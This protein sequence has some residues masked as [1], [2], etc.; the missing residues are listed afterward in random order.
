M[1][2]NRLRSIH[3]DDRPRQK[4]DEII[5]YVHRNGPDS[6][7]ILQQLSLYKEFSP[8]EFAEGEEHL[9]SSMGLFYKIGDAETIYSLIMKSVGSANTTTSGDILTPVQASVRNA[10]SANKYVSISAPTSAGKS[11]AIRDYL[12][13]GNG[14]AVIVVPSRALIAEYI[15]SLREQFSEQRDV[16][17]M[18][19]VD[20]IFTDRIRRRVFVLT[21]ERAREV[22]SKKRS[23]D[24]NLFFF[25]EAHVSEEEGRGVVFDLLVRRVIRKFPAAKLVFAH[26]F[27]E[28]PSAQLHKH[29]IDRHSSYSK[30]YCHG[31]V[32]KI[33][34]YRHK[35]GD[36]YYFSPFEDKG[37]LQKNSVKF[38]G[39]FS[40][41][42][43]DPKRTLLAYVSKASI[44]NGKFLDTFRS[45]IRKFKPVADPGAIAI[46]DEIKRLIGADGRSQRSTMVELMKV[47][48]VIHHGSV[49]L[50]VRFL[51]ERFIRL[52]HAR[53]CF[54]TSTLAQGINMPFD[55]VWLET[56]HLS[57]T[58]SKKRSLSFKNLIGRAGRLTREKKFDYGYVYTKNPLL[59]SERLLDSYELSSES[60]LDAE[61]EDVSRDDWEIV[62][63]VKEETYDD[64][65]QM[66]ESRKSRLGSERALEAMKSILDTVYPNGVIGLEHLRGVPGRLAR[67][68]LRADFKVIY[69]TY[70]GR[71]LKAGEAAVFHEAISVLSQV[72]A[73]RSFKEIAGTRFAR[74]SRRDESD[75]T[76]AQFS[77][78]AAVLPNAEMERSFPVYQGPKEKL[79]Y[80]TI[81]F[82]TYDYMDKVVSFCLADTF[83]AAAE[84]FYM[85]V[86]DQRALKLVEM[87][88]YGTNDHLSILLMRYGF[89][90]EIV[91]ELK[92]VVK[93]VDEAGIVFK[94]E[95]HRARQAVRDA[96]EWYL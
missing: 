25:D 41:F 20:S 51:I 94:P 84:L 71:N 85:R 78:M 13:E 81:V 67:E 29:G 15:S 87:F 64:E 48:V 79:P 76:D 34:I 57:D 46:I 96:V 43:L 10:I 7:E 49:P 17:I 80:D 47:G 38:D 52:K 54:A 58:T 37:H 8:L 40:E 93:R 2:L 11:Y 42:A 83:S 86:R 66:P 31:A 90:P 12:V 63:A 32:G 92:S 59:L 16:M 73:G 1:L 36:D 65:M 18:P 74:V 95:V 21:P 69:E 53:I 4:L 56:M 6:N 9:I 91:D 75:R 22:V 26:P 55:V 62:Q 14:D 44:Y 72:F 28:N 89:Q 24:V 39:D 35:N 27:V 77:Q 70:L 30:A 3:A 45:T 68:G 88:R 82:D 5:D 50:E 60:V 33:F 19:F 61:E 23:L